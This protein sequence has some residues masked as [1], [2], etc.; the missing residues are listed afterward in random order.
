VEDE[1]GEEVDV[2]ILEE[3]SPYTSKDFYCT[4]KY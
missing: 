3:A 1:N 2:L 4:P